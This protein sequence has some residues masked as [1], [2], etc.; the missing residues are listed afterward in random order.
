LQAQD[1]SA[2]SLGSVEF[3][4]SDYLFVQNQIFSAEE[5]AGTELWEYLLDTTQ[6]SNGFYIVSTRGWDADGVMAMSLP[7]WFVV[8]NECVQDSDCAD[9]GRCDISSGQCVECFF[10]DD[11]ED[12]VFCNGVE[13]CDNNTFTCVSGTEPC[14]G[15]QVCDEDNATCAECVETGDCE[16]GFVCEQTSG[17]CAVE[18]PLTVATKK[19]KPIIVKPG[20]NGKV[21][22]DKKVKLYLSGGEGF[23]PDGIFDAGPFTYDKRKYKEKTG[24]LQIKLKIPGTL[25]PGTYQISLGGCLGEVTFT[26]KQ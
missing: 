9:G 22:K 12:G 10:D 16:F 1:L 18:C 17:V 15:E 8:A 26:E 7:Q 5:N 23:D 3:V 11:C 24:Q 20:K 6:M 14:D 2:C 21:R 19:D 4:V 25:A 13:T